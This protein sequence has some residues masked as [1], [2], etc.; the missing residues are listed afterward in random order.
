M[1]R[2]LKAAPDGETL[3][4]WIESIPYDETR[5]YTKRVLSS[6]FAYGW[7]YG[8]GDPVPAL[9]QALPRAES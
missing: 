7:L 4:L 1:K 3:D 5:G 6:Y 8:T 9:P 2:W